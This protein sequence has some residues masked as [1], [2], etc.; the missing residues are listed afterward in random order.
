MNDHPTA[1]GHNDERL[2]QW[3]SLRLVS[4][5]ITH[6]VELISRKARA[7]ETAVESAYAANVE[8]I[9]ESDV[10]AL[11]LIMLRRF[12]DYLH[13]VA[14]FVGEDAARASEILAALEAGR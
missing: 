7:F 9:P 14:S 3:K 10:T 12:H 6:D 11:D 4:Q 1:A 5:D 8:M 2:D 13:E